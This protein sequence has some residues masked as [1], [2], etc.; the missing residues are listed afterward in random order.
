MNF[1]IRHEHTKK[2]CISA[3][4]NLST[5]TYITVLCLLNGDEHII[6]R[7]YDFSKKGSALK[8]Y[9]ELLEEVKNEKI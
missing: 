8:C 7:S 1:I 2:H 4:H 9:H 5:N 6:E 3:Y